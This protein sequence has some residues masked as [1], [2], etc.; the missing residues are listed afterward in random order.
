MVKR[1]LVLSV[2]A[3]VAMALSWQQAP[4][5]AEDPIVLAAGDIACEP[6][7]QGNPCQDEATAGL[8]VGNLAAILPLGD[9]QYESGRLD[10]YLAAYD[11]TWGAFKA[12]T[13]PVPGNHEYRTP[14]ASGYFSY[15]GLAAGDPQKGYYSYDIG[16]WHLVAL[17]SNCNTAAGRGVPGGCTATSP[18]VQWLKQDLQNDTHECELVYFHHPR[19][20]SETPLKRSMDAAWKEALI[21]NGVDV[22]LSGH[23]HTYERFDLQNADG[24]ATPTGARQF[25]VGTGGKN[26][27]PLSAGRLPNSQAASDTTFGVLALTLHPSSYTWSFMAIEGQSFMDTGTTDCHP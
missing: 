26:T 6:G 18:M 10:H 12:A 5:G 3:L 16:S 19:F 4:A 24:E 23:S 7:D 25:V 17:N 13:Y 11:K 22:V 15:F 20:T 2:L 1:Y 8:L 14:N 21:P 9:N 27:R